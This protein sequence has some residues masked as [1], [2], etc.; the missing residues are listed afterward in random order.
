VGAGEVISG[1][2]SVI[3]FDFIASSSND[4]STIFQVLFWKQISIFARSELFIAEIEMRQLIAPVLAQ[5]RDAP[6]VVSIE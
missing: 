6:R 4:G 3:S 1:R 5:N 2:W